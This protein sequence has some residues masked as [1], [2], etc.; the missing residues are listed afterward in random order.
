M[1]K[2]I[3]LIT[4]FSAAYLAIG[5][6]IWAQGQGFGS[7]L[8]DGLTQNGL[9][10]NKVMIWGG[11]HND[12]Y[13]YID[14]RYQTQSPGSSSAQARDQ[15]DY[16][17]AA[18]QF[19]GVEFYVSDFSN[20]SSFLSD[21]KIGFNIGMY[22]HTRYSQRVLYAVPSASIPQETHPASES[23]TIERWWFNPGFFIGADKKWYEI[24][25]GFTMKSTIINEKTRQHLDASG[26][27]VDVKGRGPMFEDSQWLM[28]FYLRLGPEDKPH[29]SMSVYRED[30]DP[31]YGVFQMKLCFPIGEYFVFNTGGYFYK[32]QTV[33]IEPGFK[34]KGVEV[35]VKSGMVINYHDK[36]IERASIKDTL[37]C[38]LKIAY[39]W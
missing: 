1:K 21:M 8:K 38:E 9:H 25:L 19:G 20:V 29:M 17:K 15:G 32:T 2:Q 28:N 5:F 39:V 16:I 30:Y 6:P 14:Q 34:Y 24:N 13:G 22:H 33:F 18:A 23:K 4:L 11:V 27:Y 37:F 36:A 3:L 31:V 10:H 35:S 26:T 12:L 7:W